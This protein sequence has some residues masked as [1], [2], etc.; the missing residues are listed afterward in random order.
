[1]V[2]HRPKAKR[3]FSHA[4]PDA[5][6]GPGRPSSSEPLRRVRWAYDPGKVLRGEPVNQELDGLDGVWK[7]EHEAMRR[8]LERRGHD[9]PLCRTPV[10]PVR[11]VRPRRGTRHHREARVRVDRRVV[12]QARADAEEQVVLGFVPGK[13]VARAFE[14]RID[15]LGPFDDEPDRLLI[16]DVYA[17]R[18]AWRA[19]WDSN[20]RHED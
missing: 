9:W 20:P 5:L 6:A 10:G 19:R 11:P 8:R 17:P 4:S 13:K 16:G 7:G 2:T 15:R 18:S 1:M 12:S 3:A 14:K